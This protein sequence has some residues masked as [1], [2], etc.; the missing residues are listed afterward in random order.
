[1]LR[2]LNGERE[3]PHGL[4]GVVAANVDLVDLEV[5]CRGHRRGVS[6]E[7]KDFP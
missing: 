4:Q 2:L 3:P 1:M 5:G 6:V 7:P